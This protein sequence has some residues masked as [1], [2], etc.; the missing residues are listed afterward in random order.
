MIRDSALFASGLLNPEIGGRSVRPYQPAGAS[1]HRW[2]ES[3]AE[4]RYRRGMYIEFYR[5]SPY[6][7]LA[8]FD[9]PNGYSSAC[10]RNR[11]TTALQAL[12]LLNDPVFIE[13]AQSLAAQIL[14]V[15]GNFA[16]RLD[17]AFRR[18]LARPADA[19]EQEWLLAYFD[20]QKRALEANPDSASKISPWDPSPDAAAWVSMSS[21]LLNLED[22][23][24]E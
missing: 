14:K 12:N 10:R 2:V 8:S 16:E 20:K 19:R 6:P 15:E 9:A 17:Y 13:A 21:I 11:S 5:T 7:L 3:A 23:M 1:P 22:F 4:D 18:C 24:R